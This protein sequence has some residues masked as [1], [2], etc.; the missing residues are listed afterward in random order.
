[1]N[2][3]VW[4]DACLCG[5][6]ALGLASGASAVTVKT[7]TGLGN[8]SRAETMFTEAIGR[9]TSSTWNGKY[10]YED[11][12]AP[13]DDADYDCAAMMS[14]AFVANSTTNHT[15]GGKS[16]AASHVS[17]YCYAPNQITFPRDGLILKSGADFRDRVERAN[18]Y[19][20]NGKVLCKTGTT[21]IKK[22]TG[23]D[24]TAPNRVTYL[25]KDSFSS[26]SASSTLQLP[27]YKARAGLLDLQLGG[28]VS[29]FTGTIEVNPTLGTNWLSFVGAN[30]TFPGKVKLTRNAELRSAGSATSITTLEVSDS[31]SVLRIAATND[32]TVGKLTLAAGKTLEVVSGWSPRH[33]GHLIL[34]DVSALAGTLAISV[35]VPAITQAMLTNSTCKCAILTVPV[36]FD[37]YTVTCPETM[38]VRD[39]TGTLPELSYVTET[40][41][42][43]KTVYLVHKKIVLNVKSF[44]SKTD[45]LTNGEYWSDGEPLTN[46]AAIYWIG[47]SGCNFNRDTTAYTNAFKDITF[48]VGRDFY[49]SGSDFEAKRLQMVASGSATPVYVTYG[50]R[51]NTVRDIT[52]GKT[53]SFPNVSTFT[54]GSFEFVRDT[55]ISADRSVAIQSY[56]GHFLNFRGPMSGNSDLRFKARGCT[57]KTPAYGGY[58]YFE[59]GMQN[60]TGKLISDWVSNFTN[61][62][63]QSTWDEMSSDYGSKWVVSKTSNLGAPRPSFTFDAL[64]L[65]YLNGLYN[66]CD[67][68]LDDLTRGIYVTG[69]TADNAVGFIVTPGGTTLTIKQA[70][71]MNGRLKKAGSGTL[72]LAQEEAQ[73]L[74]FA[75]AG[76]ATPVA[77]CNIFRVQAGNLKVTTKFA[78]DGFALTFTNGTSLVVTPG[79]TAETNSLYNVKGTVASECT[80]DLAGKIPVSFDTAGASVGEEL[81]GVICTVASSSALTTDS[82]VMTTA[83]PFG[84][85]GTSYALTV[86]EETVGDTKVFTATAK[87]RGAMLF[88]K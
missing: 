77:Q 13:H 42:A 75:Q 23:S 74:T 56:D 69:G 28:D 57:A 16:C 25:F 70:L 55:S 4:K 48:V 72:V 41:G 6:L 46:S 21:Y 17:L 86:T 64:K 52:G 54:A 2:T 15:F 81:S 47:N 32:L 12:L 38:P 24:A 43:T 78:A 85:T 61:A 51:A 65:Q 45:L 29:A 39:F 34:S 40:N 76:Q 1:M 87:P 73:K 80:G 9:N 53:Y 11:E 3:S 63:G 83:K 79:A 66:L 59:N 22:T 35:D 26:E 49:V 27:Q 36:A 30:Q 84:S 19:L 88:L 5:A 68:T 14:P 8:T 58:V 67:V 44:G 82:F 7:A 18:T 37:N 71:R 20:I 33:G 50:G 31:T 10:Y 60:F 62:L